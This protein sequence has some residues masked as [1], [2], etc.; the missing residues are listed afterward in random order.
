[1][2]SFVKAITK[3]ISVVIVGPLLGQILAV[4]WPSSLDA[5]AEFTFSLFGIKDEDV[6]DVEVVTQ[7]MMTDDDIDSW[8]SRLA[9]D[10]QADP[11]ATVIEKLMKISSVA[12]SRINGYFKYGRDTAIY[13][14]PE[15]NISARILDNTI[16]KTI[17]DVETGLDVTIIDS[18]LQ[19]PTKEE[20]VGFELQTLYGYTPYNNNLL[21]NGFTYNVDTIDYNYT[22][23]EYDITI[24]TSED[25]TTTITTTTTVVVTNIDVTTDNVNTVVSERTLVESTISGVVSDVTIELSNID[26]VVPIGTVVDSVD[27]VVVGPTTVVGEHLVVLHEPAYSPLQFYIVKYYTTVLGEWFYWVYSPELALHPTLD[28]SNTYIGELEMLPVITLRANTVNT[29]DLVGSALLSDTEAMTE[30]LGVDLET[31]TEG[32]V[33]SPTIDNVEDAFIHFGVK[34]SDTSKVVSRTLFQMFNFMYDDSGLIDTDGNNDFVATFQ[35]HTMNHAMAWTSQT[36]TVVSGVIGPVGNYTHNVVGSTL[37]MQFQGVEEYYTQIVIGELNSVTAI[38]REGLWGVKAFNVSAPEFFV[39]I[40]YFFTS[41]LSPIEQSEL[42]MKSML[43]STYA[44]NVTHLEYYE[45]EAFGSFMQ[46]AGFVIMVILTIVTG[47]GGKFVDILIQLA[48]NIAAGMAIQLALEML[49]K[50]TDNEFLRALG[51]VAVIAAS[52]YVGGGFEGGFTDA[53]I[54][55]MTATTLSV[56][57]QALNMQTA[58]GYEALERE[59]DIFASLFDTRMDEFEDKQDNLD[60]YLSVEYVAG[61]ATT[62]VSPYIESVDLMIYKAVGIQYNNDVLFS[63]DDKCKDYFDAKLKLSMV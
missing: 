53:N 40:S 26:E 2:S 44:A 16:L 61:L 56:S 12:R 63:Y 29:I 50:L 1:V 6:I 23:N 46:I 55:T 38:D 10:H 51:T 18:K 43:V 31:F 22:T 17:I 19:V 25:I 33:A 48:I 36:R 15:S 11:D 4:V 58:E 28:S 62:E 60:K 14:L 21:Y 52:I 24:S 27:I 3:I 30:I 37:T 59:T 42:L 7:R 20:Y 35:E 54:L 9:L 32:L 8:M 5:V 57:A 39:P 34:P 47:L 41:S 49:F 13:G 45:T